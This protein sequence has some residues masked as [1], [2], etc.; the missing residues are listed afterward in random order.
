ML[1]LSS[2]VKSEC[3][4]IRS[5]CRD[6]SYIAAQ[7][8]NNKTLVLLDCNSHFHH[9]GG[10]EV[11]LFIP[12]WVLTREHRKSPRGVTKHSCYKGPCDEFC[13]SFWRDDKPLLHNA[14][15]IYNKMCASYNWHY[16]PS[17]QL[18]A[19]YNINWMA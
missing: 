2:S 12:S 6:T 16:L 8:K 15:C 11:V 17:L 5:E 9:W 3:L 13:F 4:T 7:L 19:I 1:T 14:Y 10:W 18:L